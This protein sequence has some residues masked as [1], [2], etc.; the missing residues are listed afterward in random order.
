MMRAGLIGIGCLLAAMC[1]GAVQAQ[2]LTLT[3]AQLDSVA[4]GTLLPPPD[5]DGGVLH[6]GTGITT[7][8]S[9]P[10]ATAVAVCLLCTGDASATAVANAVGLGRADALAFSSGRASTYALSNAVGPYLLLFVPAP[11]A[12]AAGGGAGRP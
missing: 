7:Q 5:A 4:A 9:M 8:I 6:G 11:R 2:P 1:H 10:T 12:P 3:D